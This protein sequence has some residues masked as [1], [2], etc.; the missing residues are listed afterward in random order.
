MTVSPCITVPKGAGAALLRAAPGAPTEFYE[1]FSGT[2]YW[3]RQEK[4]FTLPTDGQYTVAVWS[5]RGDV[6][7][8]TLVVGDREVMGGDPAFP[9][10]LRAF[11][12][13]VAAP[14]DSGSNCGY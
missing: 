9:F 4:R 2:R 14:K 11:W 8:Y 6:G 13:P 12:T 7:R 10:K 1:P 5:E 3:E